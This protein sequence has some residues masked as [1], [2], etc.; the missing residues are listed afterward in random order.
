MTAL[1]LVL[2]SGTGE[3][4]VTALALVFC[5]GKGKKKFRIVV[6][7]EGPCLRVRF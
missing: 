4:G 7:L 3:E 5:E 2:V 1:A 6:L